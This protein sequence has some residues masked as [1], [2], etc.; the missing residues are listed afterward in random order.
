VLADKQRSNLLKLLLWRGVATTLLLV[1]ALSL[2][3]PVTN[4]QQQRYLIDLILFWVANFVAQAVF[5]RFVSQA[6]TEHILYQLVSDLLLIGMLI[7]ITGGFHSPFVLL[8]GLV[9]VVAGTQ[10]RVLLVLSIAVLACVAYLSS[11]YLFAG[12][13]GEPL[14]DDATLKLL[15]QTSVFLLVGGVMAMIARRHEILTLESYRAAQEHLDLQRLHSDL[16]A[17][18]QEGVLVLDADL[19]VV[20]CNPAFLHVLNR[21][22]VL[23]LKL[24]LLA[25]FP[26]TLMVSLAS[27]QNQVLRLEW[28]HDG[29]TYLLTAGYFS[30]TQLRTY[31]WLTLVDISMLR[32]LE[33]K[34]MAQERLASLGRLAAMMAHEFRNPMQTIAQATELLS[35]VPEDKQRKVQGIVAEEVQRLNRLVTDILDYSRPVDADVVAMDVREAVIEVLQQDAFLTCDVAVHVNLDVIEVDERHWRRVLENL[36]HH[37]IA[38]SPQ[39]E[40]VAVVVRQEESCWCLYVYDHGEMVNEVMRQQMFEPFGVH[41]GGTGL[42][43]ATVWQICEADGWQISVQSDPELTWLCV[44]KQI[45]DEIDC[46]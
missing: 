40:S 12:L 37:A 27:P 46:G 24:S 4:A 20:D 15:L 7:F 34:L 1:V 3:W 16:M 29:A 35:R 23:G 42:G 5:C 14:P 25:D 8:L 9:I 36:L 31:C 11:V 30:Q 13:Q 17:S 39:K 32:D 18:M 43:L 45:K 38:S 41:R 28:L 26:E 6:I 21:S 2:Y 22:D 19:R 44:K 33:K 10:A